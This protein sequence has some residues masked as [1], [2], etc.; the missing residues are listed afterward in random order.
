MEW[1]KDK[2]YKLMCEKAIE[3]QKLWK[4]NWG[5][6]FVAECTFWFIGNATFDGNTQEPIPVEQNK[7]SYGWGCEEEKIWLPNQTQLQKI[8]GKILSPLLLTE[9]FIDFCFEGFCNIAGEYLSDFPPKRNKYA[10]QFNESM[11]Q[12][13]LAFT[14]KYKYK[15][16][17][18]SEKKNWIKE[19]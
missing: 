18:C 8:C 10:E 4:P 17:W 19:E 7:E 9:E 6:C 16:I 14:M 5:D 3:I 15:K 2:I 12:L 13:W 11:E 1:Y